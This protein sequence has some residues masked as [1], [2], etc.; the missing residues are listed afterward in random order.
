MIEMLIKPKQGG[1]VK[2]LI[3]KEVTASF[4]KKGGPGC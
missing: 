4:K 2:L 3:Y 1:G